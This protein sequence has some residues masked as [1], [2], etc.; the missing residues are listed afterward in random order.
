MKYVD[1][2][3][4]VVNLMPVNMFYVPLGKSSN[5]I[6]STFKVQFGSVFCSTISSSLRCM[7][8]VIGS[9]IGSM[10]LFFFSI[11]TVL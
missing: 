4:Y 2:Y 9:N 8:N 5:I 6:V 11:F 7:F 10:L 1:T 3:T